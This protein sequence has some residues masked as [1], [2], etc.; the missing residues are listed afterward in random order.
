MTF[1]L[2]SVRFETDKIHRAFSGLLF[3]FF[4]SSQGNHLD[5]L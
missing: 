4:T 1:C 5:M 3:V 2:E